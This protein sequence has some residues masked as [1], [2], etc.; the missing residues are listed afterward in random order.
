MKNQVNR[1]SSSLF[2]ALFTLLLIRVTAQS[3]EVIVIDSNYSQKQQ[4]LDNIPSGSNILE[5]DATE[6]PWKAI[7]NYLEQNQ[8]ILTLHLFANASYNSIAIGNNLYD[9]DA[10]DQE[11]ELSMLEGLYQGNNIQLLI[12]DCNL[13]S[14]VEGLALLQKI[15][16]RSYFNIGVPTKCNSL[17]GDDLVFDHTTLDQP[18]KKS[19]FQ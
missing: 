17:I 6:N 5:V 18:V 13:G 4:V 7:R 16:E 8:A 11:F 1:K 14:N 9:S 3:D 15:S 19:I 12:Y 2:F 10:V